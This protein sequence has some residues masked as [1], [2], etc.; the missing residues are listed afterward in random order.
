VRASGWT[1]RPIDVPGPS[2]SHSLGDFH[3]AR[4]QLAGVKKTFRSGSTT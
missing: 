4:E 3:W 2:S 1:E